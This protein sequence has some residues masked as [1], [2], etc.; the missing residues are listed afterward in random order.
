[1]VVRREEWQARI[2][3]GCRDADIKALALKVCT[4]LIKVCHRAEPGFLASI[5]MYKFVQV[6][7]DVSLFPI[8]LYTF[9]LGRCFSMILLQERI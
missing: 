2:Y 3:D 6:V 4:Q 8:C 1:M 5:S 9:V 7:L